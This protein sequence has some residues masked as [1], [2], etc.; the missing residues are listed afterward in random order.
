[1]SLCL[2]LRAVETCAL[3][4]NVYADL[5]PR[6]LSSVGLSIDFKGLAVNG[7]S[8]ILVVSSY[9][10]KILT[11]LAAVAALSGIILEQVS[12]HRGLGQIVD[13]YYIVACSTEHLSESQTADT[14]ETVDCNFYISH[15]IIP[16]NIFIHLLYYIYR[17]FASPFNRIL[18]KN[19]IDFHTIR[20]ARNRASRTPKVP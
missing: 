6:E 5:A 10:V 2:V 1:M 19:F 14:T 18:H 17:K 13:S 4:N 15:G 11:D 12:K 3:E 7:D 9:G 8:V 20:P 16:P